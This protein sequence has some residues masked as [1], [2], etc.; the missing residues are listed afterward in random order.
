MCYHSVACTIWD[1]SYVAIILTF[2]AN[3]ANLQTFLLQK[4]IFKYNV[5]Y[6][7]TR[8][9]TALWGEPTEHCACRSCGGKLPPATSSK[10]LQS[11]TAAHTMF[12]CDHKY[13]AT[14]AAQIHD[15]LCPLALCL[16]ARAICTLCHASARPFKVCPYPGATPYMLC[17]CARASCTLFLCFSQ[18]L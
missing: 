6:S 18:P 10:R 12:S 16:H 4:I 17:L 1:I 2:F 15:T 9:C 8:Q 3:E 7:I 14:L 5:R 13:A 11:R